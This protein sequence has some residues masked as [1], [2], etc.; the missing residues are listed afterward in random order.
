ML[1]GRFVKVVVLLLTTIILIPDSKAQ[2]GAPYSNSWISYGKP[3]V[4]VSV[5]QRGIHRLPFS[6][7]PSDF[8]VDKP[9]NMQLWHRGKQVAIISTTNNELTFF[10]VPNDG[11][12]DSLLYRPMSSRMN[13]Y[14]SMYSDQSAYFLTIGVTAGLRAETTN[15]SANVPA[16]PFHYASITS[17]YRNEYSLSTSVYL[18]PSFFN[19]YFEIGASRTGKVSMGGKATNY[20]FQLTNLIANSTVKPSV[21]L[22]VHGRSGGN[23][24][25]EVSIGKTAETLRLVH[26]IKSSGF[27]GVEYAF[28]LKDGDVDAAGKGVISIKSVSSDPVDGYSVAYIKHTFPQA[29][30]MEG[31]P[32]HDFDLPAASETLSKVVIAGI[33][34]KSITLDISD[35]DTPKLIQ[36]TSATFGIARKPGKVANLFVSSETIAIDKSKVSAINF[37]SKIPTSANY[38]IITSENYLDGANQFATY[39]SSA[40]GGGFKTLVVNIKDIYNQFNYGEPSPLAIRRFADY[41][42]VDKSLDKHLFLI[43]KSITYNERMVR[44][45]PDEVP[46]IGFPASDVL[47]VEGLAGAPRDIPAMAVGRLPA[48]SNQSILDYLAKVKEYEHNAARDYG[49]RKNILHLNGG[50]T[51]SE[52][53]QLKNL[54]SSLEPAVTKGLVGGKV[55]PFVKQQAISE[56]E[57][58]NITPQVNNGVGLITYFGHGST[59]VTD[60]N[61]GYITDVSRGYSNNAKYPM[62]YFNGCGVGNI[63][64][65]RF[66]TNPTANDRYTLSMDWILSPNRG[67]IA[68]IA[69]SFESFV[70]PS[71]KYLNQLYNY[72]FTDPATSGLS[73]GKI[74]VLL[75]KKLISESKDSYTIANVHQSLLQGDPAIR[76]VSVPS[77][78]YAV[79][80]DEGIKLYSE[81]PQKTIGTSGKLSINVYLKNQGRYIGKEI[82]PLQITYFLAGSS[83]TIDKTVPAFAYGDTLVA[84]IDNEMNLRKIE[85]RID[86]K[87]TITELSKTNNF[88]EL[89]VDWE[90]AKNENF[91]PTTGSKDIIAPILDV[92]F[93]GRNIRNDE[94]VSQDPSITIALADDRSLSSDSSHV[95]VFIKK[96]GD[97]SCD[98]KR[99]YYSS[100]ELKVEAAGQKSIAISY[101]PKNIKDAG[102]YELLVNAT[103]EAGNTATSAYQIRFEIP[104]E[105]LNLTVTASPNPTTNFVR[106]ETAL[107]A[108]TNVSDIQWEIYN[109]R[110]ILVRSEKIG[111]LLTGVK[112]WYWQSEYSPAGVYIYK[113]KL[114]SATTGES[115]VITGKVVVTK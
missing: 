56:V 106:F 24:S 46:T 50:K 87:N 2:W 90:V 64:S 6:L 51:A 104:K 7:L 43:G 4:K 26:A 16:V 41:M 73:I 39:R 97:E 94:I 12:S 79:D 80:S 77:S 115:S 82:V 101:L 45:L 55:T 114:N 10:A 21:K 107:G 102:I 29:L 57:S 99:V 20:P 95:Q 17:V 105:K 98:F 111:N 28:D 61:M 1:L 35:I 103:D 112:E 53:T 93:N 96:C 88:S 86:P 9:A 74:Q 40:D 70:S 44:E 89:D 23:R 78:D 84:E 13:P 37:S 75:A 25:I 49:W 42:L 68:I 113:V 76:V 36:G 91:Y 31:K 8:P 67:A 83:K 54:L 63:F 72:I 66:N 48:I 92:K 59:T 85:V 62:M 34:A 60:L 69:N 11:S 108:E 71:S 27:A 100:G 81:S 30:T 14:W 3:Y 5:T 58:V 109:S 38:I 110:G 32:S 22:L 15:Q 52:I 47:L 33:Q 65:A 18:R 19:S